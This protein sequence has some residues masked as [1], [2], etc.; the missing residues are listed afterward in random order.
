MGWDITVEHKC[1]LPN[2]SGTVTGRAQMFNPALEE[3]KVCVCVGRGQLQRASSR[4]HVPHFF[5]KQGLSLGSGASEEAGWLARSFKDLS[6][7]PVLGRFSRGFW[8][9]NL[10]VRLPRQAL[11]RSALVPGLIHPFSCSLFLVSGEPAGIAAPTPPRLAVH[12]PLLLH[13]Q[14]HLRVKSKAM[15]GGTE[16]T[17]VWGSRNVSHPSGAR[18]LCILRTCHRG[19]CISFFSRMIQGQCYLHHNR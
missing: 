10:V 2:D 17:Q 13:F 8:G 4:S 5:V 3:T 6:V 14:C 19:S 15:G 18:W 16:G 7:Y 11:C 9:L 1:Q 12:S